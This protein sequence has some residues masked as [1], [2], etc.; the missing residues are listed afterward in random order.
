MYLNINQVSVDSGQRVKKLEAVVNS[1]V[2]TESNSRIS[3]P[4]VTQDIMSCHPL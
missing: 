1:H 3:R 4:F 2:S